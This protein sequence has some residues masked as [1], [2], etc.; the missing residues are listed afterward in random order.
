MR[1]CFKLLASLALAAFASAEAPPTRVTTVVRADERSG[2]LVRS[3]IVTPKVVTAQAVPPASA[4][5]AD[6]N[7]TDM[8][9]QIADEQAVEAPLVH[10]VIKAESNYNPYALSPKGAQGMMQLIP[11]TARRFGVAN[12]FN[13]KQ[14][15]EG[16]VRYL[17]YLL[18]LYNGDY[19][20]AI[21]AYNAGEKAVA[22]YGGIPPYPETRNYV[23]QVAKNLK[24]AR[25]HA[26]RR[27]RTA[28]P[29]PVETAAAAPYNPIRAS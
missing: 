2:R 1:I 28:T 17:H 27:S 24:A 8:I 15:V 16:G 6:A 29:A 4:V 25:Q 22:R 23:Y 19:P 18:E 20:K 9:D 5:A 7:V 3:V 21:A 12:A 14:N 13:P 10:S 26:V 11:A